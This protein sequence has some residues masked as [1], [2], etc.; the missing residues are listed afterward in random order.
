MAFIN[1]ALLEGA[2][3]LARQAVTSTLNTALQTATGGVVTSPTSSIP[4]T[5]SV[6][7]SSLSPTDSVANGNP[8]NNQ[9]NNNNNNQSSSP[10]LFFVALGFGVVFTN[11]W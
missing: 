2:Q 9:N 5:S 3:V 6:T 10:L 11:L 4:T 1:G 8:N 7:T